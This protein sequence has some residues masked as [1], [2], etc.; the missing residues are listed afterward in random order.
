MIQSHERNIKS[1]TRLKDF[2]RGFVQSKCLSC[3][4]KSPES[5]FKNFFKFRLTTSRNRLSPEDG[6]RL[7]VSSNPLLRLWLVISSDLA[8]LGKSSSRIWPVSVSHLLGLGHLDISSSGIVG[9]GRMR[10]LIF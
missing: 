8:N 7:L 3:D 9:L 1:F 6:C 4:L 10:W 5:Q 2:W